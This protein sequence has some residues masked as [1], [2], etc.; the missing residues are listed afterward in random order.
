MQAGTLSKALL[1]NDETRHANSRIRRCVE[2]LVS[3]WL[4]TR[5]ESFLVSRVIRPLGLA[6]AVPELLESWPLK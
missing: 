1:K 4:D 3:Q 5:G 6:V 2:R